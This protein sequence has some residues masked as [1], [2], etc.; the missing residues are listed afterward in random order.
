MVKSSSLYP[1]IPDNPTECPTGVAPRNQREW[2]AQAMGWTNRKAA[3]ILPVF[4]IRLGW[5]RPNILPLFVTTLSVV[6]Q[7][8]R[9]ASIA[10][11]SAPDLHSAGGGLGARRNEYYLK[12][13][14]RLSLSKPERSGF[15]KLSLRSLSAP[16]NPADPHPVAPVTP[17]A[18]TSCGRLRSR[19]C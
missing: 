10:G 12:N 2:Q 1:I 7:G 17:P 4:G 11:R 9:S 18:R 6:M 13:K 14:R 16:Q 8:G 19:S 3:H 5:C 15:D